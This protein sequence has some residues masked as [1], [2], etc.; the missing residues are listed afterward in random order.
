MTRERVLALIQAGGAGSR[1]DVL[2]REQAKPALPFAGV[3]QLVDFPLSNLT[4]S[5]ISDVW[6]SVQ[7]QGSTLEGEVANGRPWD[8]DRTHGG[9][10]L[11]MPQQGSGG[12]D[13]EGFATGNADELYRIRDQ[14]TAFAPDVVIVMSADHVYTLDLADVLDTHRD[15][16]AEC[17]V[18]TSRVAPEQ[19]G[20]HGVVEVDDDGTVTGFAYKPD[21]PATDV[22]ATEIT[23]YDPALLVRVLEELHAELGLQLLD[24]TTQRRLGHVQALGGASEMQLLGDGDETAQVTHLHGFANRSIGIPNFCKCR[25]LPRIAPQSNGDIP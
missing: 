9:L 3:F 14:V 8:L 15:R 16:G 5:G 17:T 10:R 25:G 18:V 6:L 22:V 20:E 12:L 21:D 11:L 2:T 7:F 24:L 1:M 23:L 4:H 13:E 19:A